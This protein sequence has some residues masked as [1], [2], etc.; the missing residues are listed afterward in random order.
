MGQEQRGRIAIMKLWL[1]EL[2]N[3]N[4]AYQPAEWLLC[5]VGTE[6][7]KSHSRVVF[8]PA[9]GEPTPRGDAMLDGSRWSDWARRE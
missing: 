6:T 1:N 9:R 4:Y 7:I 3:L 2:V 8:K 5:F